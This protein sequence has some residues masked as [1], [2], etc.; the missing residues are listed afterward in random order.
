MGLQKSNYVPCVYYVSYRDSVLIIAVYV[1]DLLMCFNDMN[2]GNNAKHEL[3]Q[4]FKM[5]DLDV[6]SHCLGMQIT[7]VNGSISLDQENYID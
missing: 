6:A 5:K 1:D 4:R 2:V 7:Q 3:N